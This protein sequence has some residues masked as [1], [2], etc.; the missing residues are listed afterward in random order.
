MLW[1]LKFPP[2]KYAHSQTDTDWADS[3]FSF[4][5][6]PSLQGSNVCFC[7]PQ[8]HPLLLFLFS[9]LSRFWVVLIH[10][11]SFNLF[12]GVLWN[13]CNFCTWVCQQNNQMQFNFFKLGVLAS[14]MMNL[15]TMLDSVACYHNSKVVFLHQ[16]FWFIVWF[17]T[18]VPVFLQIIVLFLA[19]PV[20]FFIYLF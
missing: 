8:F 6:V 11:Q 10:S 2:Q 14:W 9:W 7:C 17:S 5:K 3:S 19:N 18:S 13:I 20:G 4:K 15:S 12:L 1:A 16:E